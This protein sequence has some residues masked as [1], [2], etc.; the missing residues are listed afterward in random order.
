MG[1]LAAHFLL[2]FLIGLRRPEK[3]SIVMPMKNPIPRFAFLLATVLLTA[4]HVHASQDVPEEGFDYRLVEPP[5]AVKAGKKIEVVEFFWYDCPHCN[6]MAPLIEPWAR[7]NQAGIVFRRV[8]FA[9]NDSAVPQQHLYYALETLGKV[10]E[11]HEQIFHAIHTDKIPLKSAEQMADYLAKRG[12]DRQRFLKAFHSAEVQAKVQRAQQLTSIYQ[13][14][15]VPTIA[16]HGRYVTAAS[17]TGGSQADALRMVEYLVGK[18][19][20]SKP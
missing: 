4:L 9:R 15:S 6:A 2:M 17:M 8:P 14:D 16:V 7:R 1:G 20:S 11:L 3:K 10:E 5:Q 18:A 13:V 19:R 12:I